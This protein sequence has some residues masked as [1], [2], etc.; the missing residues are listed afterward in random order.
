MQTFWESAKF[1][2]DTS[3][4]GGRIWGKV[5]L[6]NP[7]GKAKNGGGG[8]E[9]GQIKVFWKLGRKHLVLRYKSAPVTI[10]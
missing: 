9:D 6:A 2:R 1:L 3:T 5:D 8:G 7:G 4:R 10:E